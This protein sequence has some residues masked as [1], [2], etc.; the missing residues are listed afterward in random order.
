MDIYGTDLTPTALT[1]L[2]G[3]DQ[4]AISQDANSMGR[5]C[6][7]GPHL[8]HY[9]ALLKYTGATLQALHNAS[10]QL[11]K[12]AL[13]EARREWNGKTGWVMAFELTEA[14]RDLLDNIAREAGI[15]VFRREAT[16]GMAQGFAERCN[17]GIPVL[18]WF[19]DWTPSIIREGE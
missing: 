2:R 19:G 6:T 8:I 15:W 9:E 12:A 3:I 16:L 18:E 7:P 10:R 13:I 5:G 1:C 17:T 4:I 14:G 11:R